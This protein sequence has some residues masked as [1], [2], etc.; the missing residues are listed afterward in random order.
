MRTLSSR[1]IEAMKNIVIFCCFLSASTQAQVYKIEGTSYDVAPYG[2]GWG[3]YRT[4]SWSYSNVEW[5]AVGFRFFQNGF[6]ARN[7]YYNEYYDGQ[8][9]VTILGNNEFVL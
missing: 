5:L 9:S 1:K 7:V 6:G 4:H 8:G 3:N 2:Y